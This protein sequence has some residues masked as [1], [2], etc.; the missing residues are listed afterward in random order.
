MN[1]ILRGIAALWVIL[2]YRDVIISYRDLGSLINH[3]SSGLLQ[4]GYSLLILSCFYNHGRWNRWLSMRLLQ[5]I[6]D[7]T[8]SLYL[9]HGL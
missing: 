6:G 2:F 8:Y 4:E 5:Y 9:V 1:F 3:E 7:I